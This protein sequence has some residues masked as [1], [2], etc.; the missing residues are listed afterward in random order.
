MYKLSEETIKRLEKNIGLTYEQMKTM[1]P[2]EVDK[3]IEKK[4]GKKLKWGA[5]RAGYSSGDDSVLL[6]LGRI[7]T[8]EQVEEKI[9]EIINNR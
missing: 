1:D 6:S 8:K 2:E 9:D 3:H 7:R 5:I 4:T